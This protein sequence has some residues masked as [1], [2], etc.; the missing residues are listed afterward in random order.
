MYM[1]IIIT[2]TFELVC[3]FVS[4]FVIFILCLLTSYFYPGVCC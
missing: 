3:L 2:T 1:I 4:F